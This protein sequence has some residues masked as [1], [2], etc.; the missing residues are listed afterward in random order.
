MRAADLSRKISRGGGG[1]GLDLKSVSWK[2]QVAKASSR[3]LFY[4]F[5]TLQVPVNSIEVIHKK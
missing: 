5:F 1:W 4:V 2:V 3:H